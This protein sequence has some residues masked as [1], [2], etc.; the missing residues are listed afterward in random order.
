MAALGHEV[1][2]VD[3]DEAKLAKLRS[4][5]LPFFEPGLDE[6]TLKMVNSGVLKF[7][8][9]YAEAADFAEAFF[10]AVGTPQR[11]GEFAADVSALDSAIEELAPLIGRPSVIFGKSTVPVGTAARLRRRA[12]ELSPAGD[13][14]ELAW[15]PEFLREGHAITDTV[16]PDRVVL[17][18]ARG[19]DSRSEAVARQIY[20]Q[21][22]DDGIPFVVTDLQRLSSQRPPRT[23][24]LPP[25][26]RSSTPYPRYVKRQVQ[27]LSNWRTPSGT[28]RGSAAHF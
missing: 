17:G 10:I 11:H 2:G 16:R 19:L 12:R 21:L 8:S 20:A 22:V 3:V 13:Q 5:E 27:M 7:T 15:N 14:L 6:A 25:K 24:S 4:G 23:L 26:S 9:T 1:L 18:T 28:T